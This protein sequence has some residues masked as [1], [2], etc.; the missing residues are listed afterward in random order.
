VPKSIALVPIPGAATESRGNSGSEGLNPV[1]AVFVE[2]LHGGYAMITKNR[3]L[4]SARPS[5]HGRAPRWSRLEPWRARRGESSVW[6]TCCLIVFLAISACVSRRGEERFPRSYVEHREEMPKQVSLV[7]SAAECP[8]AETDESLIESE[9]VRLVNEARAKGAVCGAKGTFPSAPPL[10]RL[11]QL[12]CAA[13]TQARDMAELGFFSHVN[14]NGD[15]PQARARAQGFQGRVTEN[16]AWGQRTAAEAVA[17]WLA[18]PDHCTVL[19]SLRYRHTG[20]AYWEGV[21][22][23]PLWVQVFGDARVSVRR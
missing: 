4:W 2:R 9:L 8:L 5:T 22:G 14:P 17:R 20:V 21:A 13:R 15:G 10:G 6:A 1:P 19:M 18:S 23:K 3:R 16:L 12:D 11:R 7:A